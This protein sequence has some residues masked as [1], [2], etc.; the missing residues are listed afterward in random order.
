[1]S[2]KSLGV[3]TRSR[4]DKMGCSTPNCGHDHSELFLVPVCHERAGLEVKYVKATGYLILTCN[5]CGKL[6]G[7]I[8]VAP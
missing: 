3:Q 2:P 4:L 6:A 8:E 5:E 1:M 7:T